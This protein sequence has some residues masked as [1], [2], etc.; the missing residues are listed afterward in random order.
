MQLPHL[1]TDS[2]NSVIRVYACITAAIPQI[3]IGIPVM[4][5]TV[6][7][8]WT[9]EDSD[10]VVQYGVECSSVRHTAHLQVNNQT[11]TAHISGLLHS[12]TYDCCI[13]AVF[14]SYKTKACVSIETGIT[15]SIATESSR[16]AAKITT[17]GGVLGFIIMVLLLMLAVLIVALVYPCLIR[18]RIQETR[19]LSRYLT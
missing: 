19:I 10:E 18:P 12:S 9:L 8:K 15:T 2:S 16:N 7:L 1:Y 3:I 4:E 13:S 6:L 11:F 5:T 17:V 14:D